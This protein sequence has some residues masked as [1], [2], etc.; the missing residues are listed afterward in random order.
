MTALKTILLDEIDRNGPMAL[1]DYMARAL[2]DATHGY[3]MQRQ[4]FGIARQDG[5]D[6]ITAPEVSQMFGELLGAWCADLWHRAGCP[7]PFAL[8]ELGPGRGTLMADALRAAA[9]AKG[10]G[11]AVQVH[12]VETSP[13]LRALQRQAVPHAHWHD[14]V[15]SLPALPS[16]VLANEFFDA[17]PIAQYRRLAD[18]WAEIAIA[19]NDD[20]TGLRFSNGQTIANPFSPIQAGLLPEQIEIGDIVE[21]APLVEAVMSEMSA[22]IGRHGGALLAIDYGY[23]Q[24][25]IGDSFQALKHHTP[26]D[27]LDEPGLADLTAHVNFALLHRL[28]DKS[29]LRAAPVTT[30]G[31]FLRH[32]GLDLRCAALVEASPAHQQRILGE[33][34]RLVGD[35]QMGLLFKVLG[36]AHGDWPELAGFAA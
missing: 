24:P 17:L 36:A 31:V 28:A 8:V 20:K 33:R 16:I 35:D 30:Q 14:S 22:H 11:D 32:L 29:G 10:F 23:A 19:A 6:F 9:H 4:P 34:D 1:A 15:T 12:F 25:R 18:G 7:A 2:G 13:K 3:Y 26:V 21:A 5:G 27:P